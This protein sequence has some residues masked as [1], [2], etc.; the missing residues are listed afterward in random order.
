MGGTRFWGIYSP[1]SSEK[2]EGLNPERR[3]TMDEQLKELLKQVIVMILYAPGFPQLAKT[4]LLTKALNAGFEF[5][6]N[7][8]SGIE[9]AE[10][11]SDPGR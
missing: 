10:H 4:E 5:D 2:E 6:I 11:P 8:P 3:G 7:G 1:S 9:D